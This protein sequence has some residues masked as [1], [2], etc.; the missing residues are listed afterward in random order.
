VAGLVLIEIFSESVFSHLTNPWDIMV[1]SMKDHTIAIILIPM[2]L[3][4][5]NGEL[6]SEWEAMIA[7]RSGQARTWWLG[8]VAADAVSAVLVACGVIVLAVVVSVATHNWTWSWGPYS[9]ADFGARLLSSVSHKEAWFWCLRAVGLLTLGLWSI[10]VLMH[11]FVLWWRSPW[12][13]WV[14]GI[15][16]GVM[17]VTFEALP[18]RFL[19]WWLPGVQFS[20]DAHRLPGAV[21]PLWSLSY[22]VALVAVATAAGL[23]LADSSPWD[24]LHGGTIG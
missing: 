1:F 23:F 19:I 22:A 3:L 9:R 24:A 12:L 16:S 14:S 5:I 13:A 20:L 11:V 6:R 7:L 8:H 18:F 10:G 17:G 4:I 2:Y 21:T 15:A